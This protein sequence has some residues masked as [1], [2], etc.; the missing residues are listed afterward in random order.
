MGEYLQVVPGDLV[1]S[2][3]RSPR[4]LVG[5]DKGQGKNAGRLEISW[6]PALALEGQGLCYKF[7]GSS[8]PEPGRDLRSG[9]K[10]EGQ[11]WQS[12]APSPWRLRTAAGR[13]W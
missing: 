11:G 6:W 5:G 8:C 3:L 9:N 2:T 4:T 13:R 12:K 7:K 1:P 10:Q